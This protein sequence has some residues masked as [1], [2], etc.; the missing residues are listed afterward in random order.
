MSKSK[1]IS[2]DKVRS[3]SLKERE[4]KVSIDDF[5]EPWRSGG[6]MKRW[7]NSL[8]KI[9]AGDTFRKVVNHIVRAVRSGH[10]RTPGLVYECAVSS[11][12]GKCGRTGEPLAMTR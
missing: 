4:S 10:A 2:L 12:T 5:G 3:Y 7:I 8:P 6:E 9:L 11:R 1:P